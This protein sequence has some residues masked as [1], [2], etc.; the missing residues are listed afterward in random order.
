MKK[1]LFESADIIVQLGLPSDDKL[2]YLKENQSI[3]GVLNPYK[4]K[5]NR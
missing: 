5:K 2:S 3:I 1:D 4:I